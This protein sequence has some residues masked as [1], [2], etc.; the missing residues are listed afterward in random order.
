MVVVKA[1]YGRYYTLTGTTAEVVTA[2]NAECVPMQGMLGI[3][4]NG[5]NTTAVYHK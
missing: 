5:T 4:Y 3:W 1:V 2:L